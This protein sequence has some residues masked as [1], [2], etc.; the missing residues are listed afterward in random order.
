MI[1]GTTMDSNPVIN[2]VFFILSLMTIIVAFGVIRSPNIFRAALFL[3]CSF[4]TI[5]GLLILL[6]AE[7]LA[8]IQI[9]LNIG[10]VSVLILFSILLSKN[11]EE[12]NPSNQFKYQF[13]S[14][15]VVIPIILIACISFI[16]PWIPDTTNSTTTI[17][18][19]SIV[20]MAKTLL[21]RYVLPFE[22][23]SILLLSAMIGALSLIRKR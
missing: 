23:A 3:M 21:Q 5:A 4:I 22:I 18:P 17:Y 8:A 7:F 13:L 1:L 20:E 12:G 9:I 19:S 10:A 2:I 14:L 16:H 6:N 15:V 11:V